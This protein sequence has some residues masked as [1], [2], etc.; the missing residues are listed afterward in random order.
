MNFQV[1]EK[2]VYPSYG[3]ATIES[4]GARSFGADFERFYLLRFGDRGVTVLAP[5]S[6]AAS[7]GLRPVSKGRYVSR[8]LS[9]LSTG[10]CAVTADW[11]ARF[12]ENSEKMRSGDLLRAA[13]VLK[14]LLRV[15]HERPLAFR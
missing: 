6:H 7:M 1:G 11:K 10:A 14:C 4:I 15:L 5:C 12:R 3:V 13:E 9:F 8:V 2:V